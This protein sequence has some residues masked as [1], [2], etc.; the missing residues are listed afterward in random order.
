MGREI[1]V[2][3]Y[4]LA[5]MGSVPDL[6]DRW[7]G[8]GWGSGAEQYWNLSMNTWEAP[9]RKLLSMLSPEDHNLI[10]L[11]VIQGISTRKLAR[12]NHISQS[13]MWNR[14]DRAKARLR[15]AYKCP[16]KPQ[17][18]DPD[19]CI[20]KALN[21]ALNA[22]WKSGS[23]LQ[24]S[25]DL[26]KLPNIIRRRLKFAVTYLENK[27]DRRFFEYLVDNEPSHQNRYRTDYTRG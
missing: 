13:S 6:A 16:P 3:P 4:I 18:L 8:Y 19:P 11:A 17:N 20:P 14:I 27:A 15:F 21:A 26:D 22:V 25:R 24:A 12:L 9:P 7:Y 10:E 2:D 5:Q 23:I 1:L